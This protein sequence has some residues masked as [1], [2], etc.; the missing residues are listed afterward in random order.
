MQRRHL[1]SALILV[2]AYLAFSSCNEETDPISP[3]QQTYETLY[4]I[5]TKVD[6]YPLYSLDYSIDYKFDEYLQTGII[7]SYVPVKKG[8]KDFSCTCFS[9]FGENNRMLGR[10][11]DWDSPSSYFILFTNDISQSYCLLFIK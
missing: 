10:N 4:G 8:S 5:A 11:Y 6:N 2:F 1:F 7:P 9:A 3:G